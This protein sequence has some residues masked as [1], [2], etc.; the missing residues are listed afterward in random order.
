MEDNHLQNN[1]TISISKIF[2][3]KIKN[4]VKIK[5]YLFYIYYN[6][7]ISY[8]IINSKVDN[9]KDMDHKLAEQTFQYLVLL[10]HK[11]QL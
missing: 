10:V 4:V 7:N 9:N 11:V 1:I 3:N 5:C 2:K 6:N 8:L